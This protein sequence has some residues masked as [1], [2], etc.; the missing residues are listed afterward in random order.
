M[1][2]AD[3]DLERLLHAAARAREEEPTE[4][5]FGFDT[6]V[7]ALWREGSVPRSGVGGLLGRVALLSA[8]VLVVSTVAVVREFQQSNE[9]RDATTNEFAIADSVIQNEFLK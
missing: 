5:P 1:K 8:A 2:N 6:R 7:V 3:K 9:V 4:V